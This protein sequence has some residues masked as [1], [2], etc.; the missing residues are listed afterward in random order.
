MHKQQTLSRKVVTW[1]QYSNKGY[2]AFASMGRLVRIGVLSVATLGTV[3]PVEAETRSM[4]SQETE[5]DTLTL[6]EVQVTG[7]LAP[8]TQLQSARIV[9]VLSRQDIEAAGVQSTNDLLKLASGVDVRQ[10]GGF[11]IQTDISIDG[12]T[13]DQITILLN[14][15]NISNPQTG[16]LAMDLPVALDDIERIEVLAGADSR[17]YGGSAFGGCIN[18]VTHRDT[19]K[20]VSGGLE[21]GMYGTVQGDGRV[22]LTFGRVNNRLSGG[23]GRSRGGTTNDDWSR[24][25]LY[26]Q[27]DYRHQTFDLTWQFGLS[28]KAYGANTFYSAAYPDQFERNEH[29][30]ASVGAET[31]G[32]FHFTPQVYWNR[33]YDNFELVRG[34][35]FGENFHMTNVYGMRLGGYFHW[36]GGKTAIGTEVRNEGILSTNLGRPMDA[37]EYVGVHGDKSVQYNHK[38]N[39]TNVSYNL[40]HNILLDRWTLSAGLIAN[41]NT[42]VDHRFRLY[43]GVDVAYRP[44]TNWKLYASYSKGFRLPTFTDLYYKSPTLNGNTGLKPEVNHSMQLGTQYTNTGVRATLRAFYN[45]GHN[46]IDWV[47]YNSSDTYH[48]TSFE[49]DNMGVQVEGKID[50]TQLC[51]RD[52]FL[53]SLS[54]GYT[55]IHQNRRDDQ[56]IY[57]SNYALEY[58]RH[59]LTATLHHKIVSR[60]T[61]TWSLRWQDRMGEYIQYEGTYTDP[62]TGYLRGTSTGTLVSYRPYA[63]LDLKLQWT[64]RH[65]MAYVKGSN[66]TNHRYYDLGNVRQPGIWVLAGARFNFSL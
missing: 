3:T 43:P 34:E 10:R 62:N 2:S 4:A 27:G 63:T 59:K 32:R 41:M 5:G 40:E 22:A 47:M 45:R 17:V 30:M 44:A 14:G 39:R 66:I 57:R 25:Q 8:L 7:T 15:A 11:G 29:Y 6:D 54:V 53:R 50:F 1:K 51:N 38:D 65:W 23:G 58:L 52:I 36:L 56:Q 9:S 19:G 60:L 21:A 13:F 46:M 61:A 28:K 24:G 37:A 31:K 49:L 18:I 20:N 55:Y 26:Y 42:S 48:S 33:W 16:H 64:E 12:G 35:R